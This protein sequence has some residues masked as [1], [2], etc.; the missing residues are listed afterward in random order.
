M[1]IVS[2]FSKFNN[3]SSVD[4]L[5]DNDILYFYDT[6]D[7][8]MIDNIF[9]QKGKPRYIV[10]DSF[11]FINVNTEIPVHTV[12]LWLEQEL[13]ICKFIMSDQI[14][15]EHAANFLINKKQIN[16]YLAIK[17]C[18]LHDIDINYS[19]SGIG[20]S[21]DMSIIINELNNLNSTIM[22]DS[23]R[24]FLLS[25]IS[26]PAKWI[27]HPDNQFNTSF[28]HNYGG[29]DWTWNNGLNHVVSTTAVSL[30]TES[31]W[32]QQAI[33]FSEKTAYSV[34]GLTFPIW[35]GGSQQAS[36]WR[37]IGFDTFDD[38][39]DHSYESMGTLI[40]RCWHAFKLNIELLKDKQRLAD[41]RQQCL[42]RLL[43]NR[44]LL[45]SDCLK[46]HNDAVIATWPNDL[47]SSIAPVLDIFR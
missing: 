46:K 36:E 30:I 14:I 26:L 7:Q 2:S 31:V 15:T 11:S 41:L 17:L 37:R 1:R 43:K 44:K 33:H 13:D 19:W 47:K 29:N 45:S 35:I 12:N 42:P 8:E 34:L 40:E 21:F 4:H 18:E 22:T 3:L 39:I 28:V 27:Q 32:T 25:P 5:T 24:G 10:G 9:R 23:E 20:N 16:R 38:I 6:F